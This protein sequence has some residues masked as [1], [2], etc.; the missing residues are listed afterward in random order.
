MP[1]ACRSFFFDLLWCV[2]CYVNDQSTSHTMGSTPVFKCIEFIDPFDFTIFQY[3]IIS[4]TKIVSLVVIHFVW[5]VAM[6]SQLRTTD[7]KSQ[8]LLLETFVRKGFETNLNFRCQKVIKLKK[9]S[10]KVVKLSK[11]T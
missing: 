8:W 3:K 10:L 7:Y 4:C 6:S 9:Y 2:L 5:S 11:L 1:L